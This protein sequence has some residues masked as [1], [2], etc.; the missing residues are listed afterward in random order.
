MRRIELLGDGVCL[1]TARV[2]KNDFLARG[3]TPASFA[4]HQGACQMVDTGGDNPVQAASQPNRSTV[5]AFSGQE[6]AALGGI[7]LFD[8]PEQSASLT[9]YC[10]KVSLLTSSNGGFMTAAS[11]TDPELA[12]GEQFCL[13]RTYAINAGETRAGKVQGVTQAQIDSQCD[14]FGPAVQPFLAKLG[15]SGSG[16]VMGD[17][18]KFV[19][20]SGMSLDQLANTAGICLFSGYRRDNMDV[21][22]GARAYPDRHRQAPL[23]RAGRPPSGT[24]FRRSACSRKGTGLVR[25]GSDLS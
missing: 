20:Q 22:L 10:S 25:H 1:H 11:M 5:T 4:C 8:Q 18:Q 21:A 9:S 23:C 12:L 7:T 15:S 13:A 3:V 6:S 2:S 19:L 14:A 16:E 24:G 17:V